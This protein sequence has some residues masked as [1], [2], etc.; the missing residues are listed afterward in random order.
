VE[1]YCTWEMFTRRAK[2]IRI[3]SVRISGVLLYLGN[4]YQ[5]GQTDPDNNRPESGV[6]LYLGNVYQKGQS[7][8][9]NKRPDKW[10]STVPGKCLPEGP[11]RSG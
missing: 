8:P 1:F 4:V 6:L 11:N 3:T 10:S 2:A 5:K 7:D 9:D